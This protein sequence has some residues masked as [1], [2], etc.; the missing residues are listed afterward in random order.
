MATTHDLATRFIDH[1]VMGSRKQAL[2]Y[3][4]SRVLGLGGQGNLRGVCGVRLSPFLEAR[5]I[6]IQENHPT[7]H[8]G[9]APLG[10]EVQVR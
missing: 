9:Q 4:I 5:T 1:R 7:P 10:E 6:P 3:M 8:C 2:S